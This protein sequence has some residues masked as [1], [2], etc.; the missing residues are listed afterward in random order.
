MRTPNSKCIICGKPLYR[1]PSELRKVRYVACYEHREEAKRLFPLTEAQEKSLD[2]G[3]EKGTNHLNGIPKS[4]ESKR[5]RSIAIRRRFT[6]HPEILIE[7]GKKTRGENHYNWRGGVSRLNS[8]IR[9]LTENRKWADAVKERD[10]KCVNCGSI[11]ILES[12]HIIPL[13]QLVEMNGVTDRDMAR[14]TPEL[15]NIENG[16]TLCQPCHYKVHGRTYAD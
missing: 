6:E 2:L 7:R 5:K 16:I 13:A 15:W 8:S 9:R 11:E 4:E 10:G 3:H 14:N 1:R 12:H